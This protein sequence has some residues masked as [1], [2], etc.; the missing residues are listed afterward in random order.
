M[1]RK[2]KRPP[3][4]KK[5]D[6]EYHAKRIEDLNYYLTRSDLSVD[7]IS[8]TLGFEGRWLPRTAKGMFKRPCDEKISV[9]IAFIKDYE[10]LQSYYYAV[11]KKI[12]PRNI[13]KKR[14]D[15][16]DTSTTT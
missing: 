1:R 16:S 10:R 9:T 8:R 5:L 11:A 2:K 6:L 14:H 12:K 15:Q 3:P 7:A 13:R 4:L